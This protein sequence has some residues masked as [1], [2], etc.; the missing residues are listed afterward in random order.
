MEGDLIAIRL[1]QSC[2]YT[3]QQILVDGQ[4]NSSSYLIRERDQYG[5]FPH[6]YAKICAAATQSPS[7]DGPDGEEDKDKVIVLSDTGCGPDTPN[8]SFQWSYQHDQDDRDGDLRPRRPEP[9]G[10]NLGTF[11]EYTLNPGGRIPYLVMTTH[12]HYDHIM[13]IG[14][15]P[16]TSPQDPEIWNREQ[17]QLGSC[18]SPRP[19]T[20]VLTS[21]LGKSF[22]TPYSNLQHHSLCDTLDIDA[23][24]YTVG[25]WA[26]DMSRVVYPYPIRQSSSPPVMIST[27]ITVMQTPGH[28]PDSIS[29]YDAEL[30]LLC[31][32]DSFYVKETSSTRTAPWGPEPPMPTMFD[33]E[34]DLVQ[35]WA[36]LEKVLAFVKEKNAELEDEEAKKLEL[37]DNDDDDARLQYQNSL[38]S[39]PRRGKKATQSGF[40]HP[41]PISHQR[42][43]G[44][45]PSPRFQQATINTA[46]GHDNEDGDDWLLVSLPSSPP[47]AQSNHR[48][49][50]DHPQDYYPHRVDDSESENEKKNKNKNHRRVRLAAAHTTLSLDAEGAIHA[51]KSFMARVLRDQVP[52][53][54]IEDGRRGEERW[55]W[56][57]ALGEEDRSPREAVAFGGY[58]YSLLSPVAVI[59][60]GRKRLPRE[61]W[62][63]SN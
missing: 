20:T 45:F 52:C 41:P 25:I 54:R 28:T 22:V 32:G 23:P 9:E 58:D 18:A 50:Y 27:P 24:K 37:H 46:A 33:V 47:P 48:H 61:M 35:W 55:V 29:W 7:A 36:S 30:R 56:D 62:T 17:H 16:P 40:D 60:D 42:G 26:E 57:Y 13:G 12:C 38:H 63:E 2:P 10:W 53:R 8:P 3:L 49:R 6:I 11:L 21:S 51:I 14:K 44:L 5:E 43:R 19:P 4:A 1:P 39:R 15:L 31:V 34:S 59:E